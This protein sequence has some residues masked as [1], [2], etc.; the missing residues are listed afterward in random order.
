MVG[1]GAG[2]HQTTRSDKRHPNE[3][4]QRHDRTTTHRPSADSNGYTLRSGLGRS[5]ILIRHAYRE[6][7]IH[8][9]TDRHRKAG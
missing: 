6:Y 7:A 9:T 2:F 8:K 5:G 4:N 1:L 3:A